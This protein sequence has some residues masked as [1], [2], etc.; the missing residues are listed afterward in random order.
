MLYGSFVGIFRDQ[1]L[2]LDINNILFRF[3][4]S[5]VFGYLIFLLL[6]KRL[7]SAKK[8]FRVSLVIFS[9]HQKLSCQQL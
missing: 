1:K 9:V 6:E 8:L 3:N 2:N 7:I 5:S 4:N